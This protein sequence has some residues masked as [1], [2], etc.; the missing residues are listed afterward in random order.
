MTETKDWKPIDF[1]CTI[2]C[3]YC[4]EHGNSVVP[5]LRP[6]WQTIPNHY[7]IFVAG[8]TDIFA[9]EVPD[10]MIRKVMEK[11]RK[12][13]NTFIFSTKNPSRY[14]EFIDD[15]PANSLISVTVE[16]DIDH[17]FS[18]AEPPLTR[19]RWMKELNTTLKKERRGDV[20]VCISIQPILPFSENFAASIEEV[21]PSQVGIGYELTGLKWFPTPE[22]CDVLSLARALSAFSLVNIHGVDIDADTE[23][24]D[25]PFRSCPEEYQ[26]PEMLRNPALNTCDD[27]SL[28]NSENYHQFY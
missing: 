18:K 15:F 10:D 9:P 3:L 20:E 12:T 1:Q 19:L 23:L 24:E 27:P 13:W 17:H 11:A 8:D 25:W 28:L 21:K 26:S 22:F 2:E 14:F 4:P 16:S 5:M 6:G 7:A